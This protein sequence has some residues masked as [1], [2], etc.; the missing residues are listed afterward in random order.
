MG[1]GDRSGLGNGER[2]AGAGDGSF[3]REQFDASSRDAARDRAG[4]QMGGAGEQ[5]YGGSGSLESRSATGDRGSLGST[6]TGSRP[7]QS[8]YSYDQLNRDAAARRG[9]Y[10][11]Y[12]RRSTSSSRS[13]NRGGGGFRPRRR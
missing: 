12:E 4:D 1:E 6:G 8:N 9:G 11:N 5:R 13:M 2:A 3:S 7:Q 10:Q